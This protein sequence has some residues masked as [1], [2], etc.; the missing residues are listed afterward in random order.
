MLG[1]AFFQ[2]P[3]VLHALGILFTSRILLQT[4]GIARLNCRARRCGQGVHC[5]GVAG[6][7]LE[8]IINLILKGKWDESVSECGA[9]PRERLFYFLCSER[10]VLDSVGREDTFLAMA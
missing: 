5:L 2:R 3:N 7:D 9:S 1:R 4:L 6:R 10:T 8:F